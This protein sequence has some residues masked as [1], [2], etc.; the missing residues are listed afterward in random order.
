M[1]FPPGHIYDPIPLFIK[2]FYRL[3]LDVG[4]DE[5]YFPG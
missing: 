4:M 1:A 5:Y 2:P 3:I